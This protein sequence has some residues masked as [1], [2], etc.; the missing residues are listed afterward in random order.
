[1]DE[2]TGRLLRGLRDAVREHRERRFFAWVVFLPA[3]GGVPEPELER[4]A[5]AFARLHRCTS[6]PVSVLADPRGPPGYRIA[7]EAAVTVL[8]IRS[9]KVLRNRSYRDGEW[10]GRAAD[11]LLQEIAQHARRAGAS[12][13]GRAATGGLA[14][15]HLCGERA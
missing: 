9:G 8:L 6:L 7:P 13:D 14:R 1:M 3:A 12:S 11:A 2:P 5:A 4:Q 10:T 15:R